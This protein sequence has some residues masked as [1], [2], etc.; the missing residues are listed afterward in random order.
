[1]TGGHI[2]SDSDRTS[3]PPKADVRVLA[4]ESPSAVS[5][6]IFQPVKA[7]LRSASSVLSFDA[8]VV[9]LE[10]AWL[11]LP[12][13]PKRQCDEAS[14]EQEDARSGDR[15]VSLGNVVSI[16]T[17]DTPVSSAPADGADKLIKAFGIKCIA[18]AL[19]GAA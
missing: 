16:S 12:K 9:A 14:A 6:S 5:T 4:A 13:L 8:E 15:K 7:G 3:V 2:R 1:M 19:T 10:R 18:A 17:H 11:S